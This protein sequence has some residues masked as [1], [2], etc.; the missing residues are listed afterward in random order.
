MQLPGATWIHAVG[1]DM[2]HGS[3]RS[4]LR[5]VFTKAGDALQGNGWTLR[6]LDQDGLR[7]VA[8]VSVRAHWLVI[9]VLLFEVA[10]R[11]YTYFGVVR[12][13][14]FPLLL[15][16]LAA[17]NG[18]FQHRL[19]SDRP[20]AWRWPVALYALDVLV[21]SAVLVL[22]AGFGH[23]FIHLFYY[24][25]LAGLAVLFTSFRFNMLWVTIV[26][27]AYVALSL[28]VA[29]GLD[30]EAKDEKAL[31]ARVVVMY[32]VV[33]VVNLATRFERMRWQRALERERVMQNEQVELSQAIHDTA[34][35]SAYMIGMGVNVAKTLADDS[36]VELTT[37]LD[38]TSRLCR[39]LILELRH[40]IN[41]GGIY[42][43]RELSRSLRLHAASFTNVTL[44]PVNVTLTGVEP[45]LSVEVKSAL[46]SVAHNALTNAYRHAEA[47]NVAIELMF[48]HDVVSLSVSDD[49]VGLPDD[50]AERG[51]G[52][53]NMNRLAQRLGGHL[54]V[55]QRGAMGGAAVTCVIPWER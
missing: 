3:H 40:P 17:F 36:N 39:S 10:Y 38:A 30:L 2:T 20:I 45:P 16:A 13:V 55:E 22:S 34:A 50:Y 51:N 11:P 9:A 18:Y 23:G 27:V 54:V 48:A 24:P 28:S 4:R 26:S 44:V 5:R 19:R 15:L 49:G 29:D 41:V 7:Y 33:A 1:D 6:Q 14:P 21:I 8:A 12:Y 42:E 32:A 35:Q 53:A 25:A 52:F 43:G 47:G 46:F 31:L 37:T